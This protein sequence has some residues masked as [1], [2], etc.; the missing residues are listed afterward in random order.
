[1]R[2]AFD[3]DDTL[4]AGRQAF[5]SGSQRLWWPASLLFPEALRGGAAALLRQL[6]QGHEVWIYTTSHRSPFRVRCWLWCFGARVSG[7]INQEAHRQSVAGSPFHRFSKAPAAFGIDLL[8]DD[9]P[10]VALECA[11]QGCAVV[12]VAPDDADWV[13]RV[14]AAVKEIAR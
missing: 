2:I 4:I 11:E 14:L 7:V 5:A 13:G 12:I 3:L 8:I 1:M 9:L 6:A 10:G